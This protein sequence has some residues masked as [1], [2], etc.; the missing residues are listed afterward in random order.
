LRIKEFIID[1]FGLIIT[2]SLLALAGAYFSQYIGKLQPCI[3]CVYQRLPY[4]LLAIVALIA[5]R[6]HK[7]RKPLAYVIVVL[8]I[9]EIALAIYHVGIERYIFKE[10][11]ICQLRNDGLASTCSQVLFRFM[12]LS[13]AEWN[14]IYASSILYYFIKRGRKNGSFTW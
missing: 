9:G 3:L 10:S 8:L 1:D 12:N 2:A 11:Y 7:I 14:V 6:F 13:M 5:L 4:F